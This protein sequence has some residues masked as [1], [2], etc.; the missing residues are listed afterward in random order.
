MAGNGHDHGNNPAAWTGVF[1]ALIGFSLG[2][3][4]TIMAEPLLVAASVAVVALGG[5]VTLVMRSMGLGAQSAAEGR[6]DGAAAA[7]TKA[8]TGTAET[9][10]A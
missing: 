2:G 5:V 8:G 10:A 1:I 7:G 3:V 4:F 6:T 9:A